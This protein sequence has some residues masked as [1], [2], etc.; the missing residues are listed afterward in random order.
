MRKQR[1]FFWPFIFAWLCWAGM[2]VHAATPGESFDLRRWKLTLPVDVSGGL[3]GSPAEIKYP[4]LQTYT[5][6][7]FYS[8][9]DGAMVFWCPVVGVTTSGATA[10]RTELRELI[11]GTDSSV[12]WTADGTHV[13]RAQCRVTQQPDTGDVI[14]GQVHGYPVQRLVKVQYGNGRVQVYIRKS[15]TASG[16]AKFIHDVGANA[17]ID[18]EIKVVD[19]VAIVAVN[20]VTNSHNFVASDPAWGTDS[21]F[22]FKAGAYLQ[23]NAGPVTE[24]GRVSFYQ[25]SVTHGTTAPPVRP[26]V[27]TQPIS[28]TVAAGANVTL[29]VAAS[30]TAPLTYQ[31]RTNGVNWPGRTNASITITNFRA[32]DQRSYDVRVWNTAG[33]ATSAAALLHL[34]S[35]ARFLLSQ[36]TNG[37]FATTFLGVAGSNYVFETSTNLV[38]WTRLATN[39]AASGIIQFSHTNTTSPRRFYRVR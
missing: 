36:R 4:Q 32:T 1:L 12:N 10:P 31:W 29:N 14:I 18:Y 33:S 37:V 34:N 5:S 25:L 24:G 6:E 7:F 2:N 15:L 20:G 11:S 26:A 17:L 13:L 16:D 35:P 30:G 9:T 38:T 39:S 23:D 8:G 19:G 28:Q 27:T 21:T 22:Y 3:A